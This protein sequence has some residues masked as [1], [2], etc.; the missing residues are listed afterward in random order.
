MYRTLR[1]S[2]A[3]VMFLLTTASLRA[4]TAVDPSGHWEGLVQ[5]PGMD[6]AFQIDFAKSGSTIIG[7][8]SVPAQQL[9]GLPLQRVVVDGRSI[10]F[11]ARTD[12]SFDGTMSDDGGSISGSYYI[13]GAA[14]P[15]TMTRKGEA[16]IAAPVTGG[17]I[18]KDLE[19]RWN[20][21]IDVN[22]GLK[23]VLTMTN[24]P[25]GTSTGALVNLG[26]GGLEIPVRIT[27]DG[28]R[29]TLDVPALGGGSYAGTLN[30]NGTELTGIYSQGGRSVPL[31]FKRAAGEDR[32]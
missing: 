12:Q 11:Q 7:A 9:T 8:V 24:H 27:Q 23:L 26:E 30:E 21:T 19:G 6:V 17:R 15:F 2:V 4:Q 3:V 22:G 16:R 18:G 29:V 25:D 28:A 1:T 10:K 13:D 31:I 32:K 20:G 14:V 5:A